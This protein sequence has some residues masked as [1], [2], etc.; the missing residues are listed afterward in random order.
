[1]SKYED[2]C[3]FFPQNVAYDELYNFAKY[4]KPVFGLWI[5]QKVEKTP[6]LTF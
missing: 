1:M 6:F 3:K 2:I 5:G 4:T